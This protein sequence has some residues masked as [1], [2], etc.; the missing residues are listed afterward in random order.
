MKKRGRPRLT[1]AQSA[2]AEIARLKV[3]YRFAGP[4]GKWKIRQR[5]AVLASVVLLE[6]EKKSKHNEKIY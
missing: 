6:M 2:R 1:P 4:V 5:M 3:R